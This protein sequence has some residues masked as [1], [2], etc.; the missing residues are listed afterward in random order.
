MIIPTLSYYDCSMQAHT[1][2]FICLSHLDYVRILRF[3][4]IVIHFHM[5]NQNDGIDYFEFW[6]SF[7]NTVNLLGDFELKNLS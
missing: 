7:C 3:L 5:A 1:Y 6:T 4:E 2:A